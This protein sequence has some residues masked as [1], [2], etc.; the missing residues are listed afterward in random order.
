MS[1]LVSPGY[2]AKHRIPATPLAPETVALLKAWQEAET[3]EEVLATPCNPAHLTQID[4]VLEKFA[5]H[6]YDLP[7][8]VRQTAVATLCAAA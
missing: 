7:P 8:H 3:P 1:G 2:A 4:R 6:H 5:A